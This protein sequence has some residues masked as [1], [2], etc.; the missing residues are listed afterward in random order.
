MY[1][2]KTRLISICLI[3][4]ISLVLSSCSSG[5]PFKGTDK[6]IKK[7][8]SYLSE[9]QATDGSIGSYSDTA[10]AVM[11]LAACGKNPARF[12][13]PSPIDFLKQNNHQLLD[14][15]NITADL[16][17]NVLAIVASGQSPRSFGEG[18]NVVPGGDFID[19]LVKL[20]DG[21]QFG[22]KDSINEDF[23]ALIALIG[24]GYSPDDEII[25]A[26]TSY[27]LENQGDDN[28]WSWAIPHNE[29]YYE[30]DPDNTAAAIMA[31][32]KAGI[33][34][35]DERI[36]K[37]L[38][39]IETMQGVNGGYVSYGVENTS[40]TAW[41]MSALATLDITASLNGEDDANPVTYI[42]SM[43]S[44]DGSFMFASPLPEGYLAMPEKTTADSII[45]LAGCGYPVERT[46][47]NSW[48]LWLILTV[49]IASMI[50]FLYINTRRRWK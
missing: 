38:A 4:T 13:S 18:N 29:W 28:G 5:Y 25:T 31:L 21:T 15:Y 32:I 16:A 27:L 50:T 26:T 3:L 20:H 46:S 42:L 45:A 44:E 23:W 9:M 8:L 30:S 41:V 47:N 49:L 34:P 43:Q 10:W 19:A 24:A 2:R 40:S 36:Q 1:A 6:P 37:A 11:A 14:S 39:A 33:N 12:G 35:N 17:R 22:E 7:A 48:W